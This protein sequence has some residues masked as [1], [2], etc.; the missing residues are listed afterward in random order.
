VAEKASAERGEP[1]THQTKLSLLGR[2]FLRLLDII[3]VHLARHW[4][5]YTN[6]FFFVFSGLPFLAPVLMHYGYEGGGRL[7]YTIYSVTCHQFAYRS[8]FSFG[9]QSSYTVEQLQQYLHVTNSPLDFFFWRDFIGNPQLGYK[10]AYCERDV[11]MHLSMLIAGLIY[12]LR[13]GRVRS[14]GWVW[15]ILFAILPIG[16]DGGTQLVMLRESTPLLRTITGALFGALTVWK[17]YPTFDEGMRDTYNQS[18][19]QLERLSRR[20]LNPNRGV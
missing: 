9:A 11:A 15:Y 20:E 12:R 7:V 1:A 13:H 6:L 2:V 5:L 14:L 3:I 19:K 8:W 17:F 4:L 16:I 10:M 18:A